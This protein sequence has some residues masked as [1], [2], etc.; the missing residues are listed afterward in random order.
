MCDSSCRAQ[1]GSGPVVFIFLLH[2]TQIP[3]KIPVYSVEKKSTTKEKLPAAN[4]STTKLKEGDEIKRIEEMNEKSPALS[5]FSEEA[6]KEIESIRPM[7]VVHGDL[8]PENIMFN[9]HNIPKISDF[10]ISHELKCT[11]NTGTWEHLTTGMPRGSSS[12]VD[13]EFRDTGKLTP[14]ADVYAFGVVLL[15]LKPRRP[16]VEE[17]R[18]ATA[19]ARAACLLHDIGT[20]CCCSRRGAR[21]SLHGSEEWRRR[22]SGAGSRRNWPAARREG[23]GR[24]GSVAGDDGTGGAKDDFFDHYIRIPSPLLTTRTQP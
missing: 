17:V 2:L 24:L 23:G 13:P 16:A 11:T 9:A 5:D 3:R 1:W 7:P 22:S 10:G 6:N 8:K 4:N 12:Y 18:K 15:Q 19:T 20:S 14:F 21:Q